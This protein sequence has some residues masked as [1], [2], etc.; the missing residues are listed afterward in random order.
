MSL[1]DSAGAIRGAVDRGIHFR[2]DVFDHYLLERWQNH[3]DATGL[4]NAAARAVGVAHA[5]RRALHS[6]REASEREAHAPL[7]VCA[8]CSAYQPVMSSNLD[9]HGIPSFMNVRDQPGA[10]ITALAMHR[11]IDNCSAYNRKNR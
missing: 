9:S 8:Q 6:R 2:I 4:V 10:S 11:Q 1:H 3:R 7:N 5:N